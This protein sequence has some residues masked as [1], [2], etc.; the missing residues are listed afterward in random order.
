M[1]EQQINLH[2][3]EKKVMMLLLV[4]SSMGYATQ[5]QT[6]DKV[7]GHTLPVAELEARME[8]WMDSLGIPGLSV[9]IINE[10]EVAYEGHL[11]VMDWESGRPIDGETVFEAASLSKPM[12]AYFVLQLAEQ[13]R[14]DLDRPLYEYLDH[15]GFAWSARR[16]Y[17]TITGRMV[18]CHTTGMPNWSKG[19]KMKL[20]FAPGEG[21]SYSGEAYQWLAAALGTH[22]GMGHGP[23]LD[24]VFR[25]QVAEPLG[26]GH[27][28]YTWQP[29][30]EGHK[31]Y[32]HVGTEVNADLF[33]PKNVG[34]AHSLHS[35]AGDY[36]RFMQAFLRPEG[37][38]PAWCEP[39][40]ML[41]NEL[42]ADHEM[43]ETG[44]IGWTLGFAMRPTDEGMRYLH[45]G[46]NGDF[47]AYAC[48]YPERGYGLVF[49]MNSDQIEPFY[50]RLG[51]LLEDPF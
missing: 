1:A 24:S 9:A 25:A 38:R 10:G 42:P 18:L 35:N 47:M 26:M 5:A 6:I 2:N 14:I 39:M 48:F 50:T 51:E 31:P 28:A 4:A 3:M 12:F 17:K 30:Y 27:T 13:G 34:S 43:R 32:G 16:E 46:N 22:L 20:A 15:P 36:A 7:N 45:T 29:S 33:R 37:E 19:K 8:H 44:Q 40:L 11:G 41:Q 21:F 23:A 49:F